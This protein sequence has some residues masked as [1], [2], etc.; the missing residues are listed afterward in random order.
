MYIY[1]YERVCLL[2]LHEP[3]S[4]LV[5][6]Y[7]S[8][9]QKERRKTWTSTSDMRKRGRECGHAVSMVYVSPVQVS[10]LQL[11][12]HCNATTSDTCRWLGVHMDVTWWWIND[13]IRERWIDDRL[14]ITSVQA[15]TFL[16]LQICASLNRD[17][18]PFPPAAKL[19]IYELWPYTPLFRDNMMIETIAQY[20]RAFIDVT[21]LYR[22][23]RSKIYAGGTQEFNQ[24]NPSPCSTGTQDPL[25]EW[26]KVR[27][28]LGW[29]KGVTV[30]ILFHVSCAGPKRISRSRMVA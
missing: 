18:M 23:K 14:T 30:Q 10:A 13:D 19:R 28:S 25:W 12:E 8:T 21:I 15:P 7:S 22:F 27:W 5:W 20:T 3:T 17:S 26:V 1:I 9:Y 11:H 29:D 2:L 24:R 4:R 6:S 16:Q